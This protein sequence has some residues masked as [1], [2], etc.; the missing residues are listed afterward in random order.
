MTTIRKFSETNE[1]TRQR[2]ILTAWNGNIVTK[3][4]LG[5]RFESTVAF[6]FVMGGVERG[7][8]EVFFN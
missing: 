1:E 2:Y 8:H 5:V 6:G 7:R 4:F 3:V